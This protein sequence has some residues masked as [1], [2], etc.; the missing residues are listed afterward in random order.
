MSVIQL[1]QF[2]ILVLIHEVPLF[3]N[4][5]YTPTSRN[6][7]QPITVISLILTGSIFCMV[8]IQVFLIG[9]ISIL[10]RIKHSEGTE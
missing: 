3:F 2:V 10:R 8:L 9:Q 4:I 5:L 7:I 6:I 1:L